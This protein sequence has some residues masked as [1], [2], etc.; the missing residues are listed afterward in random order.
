MT[1]SCHIGLS[2]GRYRRRHDSVLRQLAHLID[3]ELRKKHPTQLKVKYIPFVKEGYSAITTPRNAGVLVTAQSWEKKLH[4]EK[5]PQFP[6]VVHT[7]LRQGMIL[8]STQVK[9]LLAIKLTVTGEVRCDE[10]HQRKAD[11]YAELI[12]KAGPPD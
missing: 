12:G 2:H 7:N 8:W 6:D 11:K 4:L 10:A 9:K 3:I 1:I 5:K